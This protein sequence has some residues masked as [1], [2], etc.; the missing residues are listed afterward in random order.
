VVR[1]AVAL[2]GETP[3]GE[4]VMIAAGE[5]A[6]VVVQPTAASDW[7]YLEVAD[8][9]SGTVV[10]YAAAPR[11]VIELVQGAGHRRRDTM[12]TSTHIAS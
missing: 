8:L 4:P 7:I 6:T 3:D 1:V 9:L 10:A 12:G 5:Q 2:V 11:D